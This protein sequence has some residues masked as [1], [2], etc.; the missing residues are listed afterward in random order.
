M[1]STYANE[2]DDDDGWLYVM[3]TDHLRSL[4]SP[5]DTT[6]DATNTTS[7]SISSRPRKY[8]S[9]KSSIESLHDS[10]SKNGGDT[11]QYFNCSS[12]SDG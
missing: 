12:M 7:Q 1:T 5:T 9:G 4:A 6:H 10:R 11:Q 2:Q 8:I 3:A